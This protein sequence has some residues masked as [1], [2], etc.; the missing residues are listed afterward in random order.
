MLDHPILVFAV[1]T[2]FRSIISLRARLCLSNVL[3]GN[4]DDRKSHAIHEKHVDLSTPVDAQEHA[5]PVPGHAAPGR[6]HVPVWTVC[7]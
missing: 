2:L 4:S 6:V 1:S 5:Y 3:D 7:G